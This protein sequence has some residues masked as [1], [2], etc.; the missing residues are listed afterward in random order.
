MGSSALPGY[1]VIDVETTGFHAFGPDRVVEVAVVQVDPSG[2]IT[3]EFDTLVNPERDVGPTHVHGLSAADVFEA[4]T[5]GE[6]LGDVLARLQGRVVVGHNVRFDERFLRAGCQREGVELPAFP[7]LCTL[8]ASDVLAIDA[9]SM[10]LADVCAAV[11]IEIEGAHSALGDARASAGLLARLL[12]EQGTAASSIVVGGLDPSWPELPS[13]GRTRRRPAGGQGE[14]LASDAPFLARVVARLPRLGVGTKG[15]AGYLD[16]LDRVL[17]DRVVTEDEAA[18]LLAMARAYGL[19]Q[20]SVR[21]L[22]RSYYEAVRAAA[23]E[24]GV[25]TP[26]EERDLDVVA[27][28]LALQPDAAAPEEAKQAPSG[29]A[30]ADEGPC[31]DQFAGKTVCFTGELMATVDGRRLSRDDATALACEAGLIVAPRVTK[32]LDFLVL[33]DVHS[34]SGKAKL[35]RK[36]GIPLL[37]E[38]HLWRAMGLEVT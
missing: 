8:A 2:R 1:A 28:L 38:W 32:R 33:A 13:S 21:A 30:V 34:M 7:T 31:W 12:S 27:R 24:D 15:A 6:V 19:G 20:D 5:F 36:Y 4:P 14:A 18:T 22:H 3:G 37:A 9:P 11:G 10:R 25:L 29:H 16:M 35:A 17:A 26:E 23:W